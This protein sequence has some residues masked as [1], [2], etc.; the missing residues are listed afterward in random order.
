MV[1]VVTKAGEQC[2][3]YFGLAIIGRCGP[4]DLARRELALRESLGGWY[5]YFH[6]HFFSED[7]WDGT[8]LFMATAD[9]RGKVTGHIYATESVVDA[10]RRAK[11]R[12]IEFECLA[13]AWVSTA[14]YEIGSR[15]RLPQDYAQRIDKAY[16][17]A[18]VSRP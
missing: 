4:E 5:P 10:I 11:V 9:N 1:Q 8:D 7:S 13:D 16:A 3:G 12:N 2:E 14:V 18:G 17:R 6:G 15:Y